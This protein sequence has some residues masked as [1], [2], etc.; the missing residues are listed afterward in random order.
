MSGSKFKIWKWRLSKHLL[1]LRNFEI[2]RGKRAAITDLSL[3][4]SGILR[5]KRATNTAPLSAT[6]KHYGASAQPLL[7]LPSKPWNITGQARSHY[8]PSLRNPGILRGKHA[9]IND[10]LSATL[11]YYGASTQSLMTLSPL[12][13]NIT[14]QARSD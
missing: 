4:Y 5:G 12:P 2:L 1:S 13:W 3:P 10:P 9:A 7:N 6:M 11:E 8:W 14:G